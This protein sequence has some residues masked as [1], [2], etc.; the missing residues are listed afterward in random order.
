[1][2][3]EIKR[4]VMQLLALHIR[5]TDLLGN[6]IERRPDGTLRVPL[7]IAPF[8]ASGHDEAQRLAL[9]AESPVCGWLVQNA[10]RDQNDYDLCT[11]LVETC[12]NLHRPLP[13]PLAQFVLDVLYGKISRPTKNKQG[14]RPSK[15][16]RDVAIIKAVAY[17]E[18][19]GIKPTRNT[20]GSPTSGCDIVSQCLV[21]LGEPI[22]YEGVKS[23]W[24]RRH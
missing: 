9:F 14:G 3:D 8:G 12:A 15:G 7:G 23:V 18:A 22:S 21:D 1:M 2:T 17:T 10:A 13:S 16:G 24:R 11:L 19:R 20:E 4:D 5:P 6:P